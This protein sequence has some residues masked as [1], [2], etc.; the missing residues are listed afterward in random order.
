MLPCGFRL[1][2]LPIVLSELGRYNYHLK[3]QPCKIGV[4]LKLCALLNV[5]YYKPQSHL[6]R[7]ISALFDFDRFRSEH[8]KRKCSLPTSLWCFQLIVFT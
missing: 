6:S 7:L 1:N 8:F 2:I 5:S 4:V 3:Q